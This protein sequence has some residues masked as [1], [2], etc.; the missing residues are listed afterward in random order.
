VIDND[1]H[2]INDS[3]DGTV[4]RRNVANHNGAVGL[5]ADGPDH[6]DAGANRARGNGERDC[7][8]IRCR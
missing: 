2:G 8:G 3:G 1:E 7:V 6:V 4:W 5:R